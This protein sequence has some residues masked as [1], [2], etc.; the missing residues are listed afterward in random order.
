MLELC[1][2]IGISIGFLDGIE[3][4][5]LTLDCNSI[6][7]KAI[8]SRDE[9]IEVIQEGNIIYIKGDNG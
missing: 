6:E 4:R 8:E 7:Y 1:M 2:V 5:V 3:Q 9:L